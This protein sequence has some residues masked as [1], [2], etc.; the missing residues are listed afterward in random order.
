[1]SAADC[2]TPESCNVLVESRF[3]PMI[4]N[5]NDAYIGRSILEYGEFSVGELEV[6]SQILGPGKVVVEAGANIGAHTLPLAKIVGPTGRV[7]AMEP[8]RFVFQTL[9]GNMALNSITN[10]DCHWV[11]VGEMSGVVQ[12]PEMPVHQIHN[13]GGVSLR[14]DLPGHKVAMITIDS[15]KLPKC[16]LLKADVEGMELEVLKGASDTITRCRPF[17]YVESDRQER[18][19]E[20]FEWIDAKGYTMY[21]HTPYLFNP[22]NYRGVHTNLFSD[23][24]SWN[25][26]CV[27]S[28]RPQEIDGLPR[29]NV[30]RSMPHT[31]IPR[32]HFDANNLKK[33]VASGE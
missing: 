12:V 11:A 29:I 18:R 23:L 19:A 14:S 22:S 1:M 8:Q 10:V 24:A 33:K 6:L 30:T 20:L 7:I 2:S 21:W 25:V 17:L 5:R 15:L 4:V 32:P 28:E 16:H 27:P 26:L 3:G 9:C 13:F 31:P